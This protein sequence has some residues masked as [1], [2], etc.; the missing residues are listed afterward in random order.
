MHLKPGRFAKVLG[1][2]IAVVH[3]SVIAQTATTFIPSESAGSTGL[4]LQVNVPVSPRYAEGA[5]VVVY[6]VGGWDGN[7]LGDDGAG[8]LLSGFIEVLFNFPGSGIGAAR[9]GGTYDQRGPECLKALRDVALF[10]MNRKPDAEGKMLSDW[11]GGVLPLT[12]NVGLMGFSNGGNATISA[13]GVYGNA[14]SGMAWI[15]NWESPVG[16]GMPNVE[17]GAGKEN[18]LNPVVN[19]AYDPDTGEWNLSTLR[20]DDTISVSS[21]HLGI[22]GQ[23]LRGGPY[24]DIDGNGAPTPGTDF[25]LYPYAV[26]S[27]PDTSAFYS[28]RIREY[29]ENHSLLPV[30]PPAHQATLEQTREF[31]LWRNGEYWIEEAVTANPGLMFLV[32]AFEEDHVQ[33]APDHPHVLIQ[34]EGFRTAGARFVRL[35]PDRSYV[36]YLI[37]KSAPFA[38]DNNAYKA[39]DHVTIRTA[40]EPSGVKGFAM[41]AACAAAACE[42]ADRTRS[43]NISP[44]IDRVISSVK[45]KIREYEGFVLLQNYPNPFNASTLIRYSFPRSVPIR[46]RIYDVNGKCIRNIRNDASKP[47]FIWRGENDSGTIV[48]SGMYLC[49]VESQGAWAE[50]KLVF[51]R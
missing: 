5:P 15:V 12:S 46:L 27:D 33:G 16:D 10:A 13:A 41:P 24:F 11:T 47:Y 17:C 21:G 42:L 20:Y 38:A 36:E 23:T 31:W 8:L 28:V 50:K 9:S 30:P 25:I 49:R 29:A 3:Y 39:F 48:P 40:V 44:Q 51:L 18:D 43:G 4:A 1:F 14:L 32:V 7:G 22:P 26:G 35:N 2:S 19:P 45:P 6:V 37:G 34:Y